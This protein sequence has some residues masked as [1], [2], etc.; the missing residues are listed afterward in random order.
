MHSKVKMM[1]P[2]VRR[3]FIRF[4]CAQHDDDRTVKKIM[5]LSEVQLCLA[6]QKTFHH[7]DRNPRWVHEVT[8]PPQGRKVLGM[9]KDA[10]HG[11]EL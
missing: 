6:R 3:T 10:V 11:E 9:H 2:Q 8:M 7:K 1:P 4:D 5:S